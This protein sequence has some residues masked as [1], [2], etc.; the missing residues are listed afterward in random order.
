MELGSWPEKELLLLREVT[1][2]W[3]A[4]CFLHDRQCSH[5]LCVKCSPGFC[6][7]GI[8][9]NGASACYCCYRDRYS[10]GGCTVSD[11]IMYP[12]LCIFIHCYCLSFPFCCSAKLFLPQLMSFAFCFLTSPPHPTRA[13]EG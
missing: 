8:S 2:V 4:L 9:S 13:G 7:S 12:C 5:V 10:G 3:G 6:S 1:A 11:C